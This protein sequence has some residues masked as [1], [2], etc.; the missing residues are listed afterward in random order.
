[1]T[2][3][4]FVLP[5]VREGLDPVAELSALRNEETF[6][7]L[8]IPDGPNAWLLTRYDDVR[9]VLSDPRFSTDF[10]ALTSISGM[11][12]FA[13]SDPGGLGMADPPDHT[14]LR[15]MLTPEFTMRRLRRL[16]PRIETIVDERLDA[17]ES[18]GAPVDLAELFAVPIPSLVICELLG[19]PYED[20]DEFQERS[21]NRFEL[22]GDFEAS[23]A[24][25]QESLGYLGGLV[26][27]ERAN[28]GEGLLGMLVREHGDNIT[29]AELAGLADGVLT[30][31]HETTA[32][33]LSLGALV[34]LQ[35]P[36]YV[37]VMRSEGDQV[38][39]VVDELLRLL[40]VVQV[41]FPRLAKEDLEISGQKIAK[42][43]VVI[44]SLSAAN[45]DS[46]LGENMDAFDPSRKIASSHLAFGHGIHRCVGA[47]LG[48]LEMRIAYPKLFTRFPGLRLDVPLDEVEYKMFSIVY[49][50]SSL[51]VAW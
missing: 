41:P 26:A 33:M 30:G 6:A 42:G 3:V 25:I 36:D 14:R 50:V 20:R 39:G 48:R 21:S 31:G 40:T 27:K 37:E 15:K 4:P 19:V 29:D 17:M 35:N 16:I 22:L 34:L 46:V 5:I 44:C 13:S 43:E 9:A 11:E 32:S 45:R 28:P 18:A 7:Q 51:P 38:D 10:A 24:A 49:G 12:I 2:E 8:E 47:E 1:M 23:L